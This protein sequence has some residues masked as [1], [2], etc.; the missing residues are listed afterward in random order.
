MTDAEIR[1]RLHAEYPAIPE[2]ALD[3][4]LSPEPVSSMPRFRLPPPPDQSVQL[5]GRRPTRGS[6]RNRDAD[7]IYAL[8]RGLDD[9]EPDRI[10]KEL[11][12]LL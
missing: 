2:T 3:R 1:A 7:A 5:G 8:L 4:I 10:L 9:R 12:G 11:L 6:R